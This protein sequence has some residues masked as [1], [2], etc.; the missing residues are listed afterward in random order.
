[1][2]E[3]I[4]QAHACWVALSGGLDSVVLLHR[5][6]TQRETLGLPLGAVHVDHQLHP[7]SAQ[8]SERCR[9]LCRQLDIPF[10]L[11]RVQ[12]R[13]CPGESPEAAAREAR[14]Q[15]LRDWL[16]PDHCLL[17]AHHEDDQA[18]TLLLQLL[19]GSGPKGLAGMPAVSVFGRGWLGRPLLGVSREQLL[20]WARDHALDWVEDPGN[21]DRRYDRNFLR[22]D[23]LPRLEARW[24]GV[25]HALARAARHQADAASLQD[26]LAVSDLMQVGGRGPATLSVTALLHYTPPRRR[27]LLRYWL[28]S[29]GLPT[30]SE[31][32][33]EQID[34]AALGARVDAM[35]RVHWPGAEVRRYRDDLYAMRPLLRPPAGLRDWDGGS[36]ELEPADGRLEVT[37]TSGQGLRRDALAGRRLQL[38]FRTGGETL[39]PAGRGH[40]HSLKQL[41]QERGIPPWERDR[42]PLVYCDGELVA[43]AGLWLVEGWQAR[44]EE[45]GLALKWSRL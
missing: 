25:K 45:P 34:Q 36:C 19:R 16:R 31:A 11:H 10:E 15:A 26:A 18:E 2:K 38:G 21:V 35:P 8:W 3:W 42:V 4:P 29:L 27:N 20:A 32:V 37:P 33:L 43:V 6:V 9:A 14:Y 30:P 13:H 1:M 7:E 40:H 22:H 24:P 28:N 12:A 39:V 41:F 23:I 44:G 5:L 17:T